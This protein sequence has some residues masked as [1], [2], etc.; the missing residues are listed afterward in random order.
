MNVVLILGNGADL[1]LGLKTSFTSFRTSKYWE[2]YINDKSSKNSELTSFLNTKTS[3]DWCDLESCLA[4]Y[5]QQLKVKLNEEVELDKLS[6][7]ALCK[8]LYLFLEEAQSADIKRNSI[9]LDVL[10]NIKISRNNLNI[11]TFNYT[12]L[13]SITQ[14]N[15]MGIKQIPI[16]V[17]GSLKDELILG[18]GEDNVNS[19]Y[20]FLHKTARPN[21]S[22]TNIV[23]D[24]MTSGHVVI[25]GHSLNEIDAPYFKE[26]FESRSKYNPNRR[27][28]RITIF[29][30]NEESKMKIQSSMQKWGINIMA[31]TSISRL[32]FICIDEYT[33]GNDFAINAYDTFIRCL[34]RKPV[35]NT[36]N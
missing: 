36:R 31:L 18:V 33:K 14:K 2:Q 30:K 16:Y 8:Q 34:N 15:G 6:Y 23:W 7:Q 13:H 4:D 28:D 35:A 27:D 3:G 12:D 21:Y 11:Y 17:H 10:T 5:G 24:M 26:F 1:D 9:L 22:A 20:F 25:F 29:T 32:N 19:K